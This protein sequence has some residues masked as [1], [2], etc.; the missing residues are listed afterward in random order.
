M[1]RTSD[2]HHNYVINE[3]GYENK[4]EFGP[5]GFIFLDDI[6]GS[7]NDI[8]RI[9]RTSY[10]AGT[11]TLNDD[12]A[13]IRRLMKDY[14]CYHP[15]ME[16]LTLDGW[17]KWGDCGPREWYMI[18]DPVKKTLRPE[19]LPLETFDYSGEMIT[20]KNN[21]MSFCVTP[22]HRMYFKKKGSKDF[23]IYRADEMPKWG[24]FDPAMNYAYNQ[25]CEPEVWYQFL[26][27]FLGDGH[28]A[29]TN[30]ISFHLVKGRKKEYLRALLA[31]MLVPF[32]EK[33]SDKIDGSL[34]WIDVNE[35]PR[36]LSAY[37]NQDARSDTKQLTWSLEQMSLRDISGLYDGLIN[38]DGSIKADR[39]QIQFSSNSPKLL[40][41][42]QLLSV[43]LGNDC[44][45]VAGAIGTVTAY[46]KGSRTT[47][48]ARKEYF[49]SEQ[50]TGKVHCVT[51]STGLLVVR[52]NDSTFGFICGNTSPF[53]MARARFFLRAPIDVVRQL[54]RHRMLVHG[55]INEYCVAP[56]TQVLKT[57]L[58][59]VPAETLELGDQLVGFSETN[60]G[61]GLVRGN[62][63]E[64]STVTANNIIQAPCYRVTTDNGSSIVVSE[65]HQWVSKKGPKYTYAWVKTT[66]L[67]VGNE[68]AFTSKPWRTESSFDAGWLSGMFD[69]EGWLS[70]SDPATAGNGST[71][72]NIH[73]GIAQ[74]ESSTLE[75]IRAALGSRGINYTEYIQNP[76]RIT[77][78]D[79]TCWSLCVQSRWSAYKLLGSIHPQRLLEKNNW[80][81]GH[82]I[83]VT[84]TKITNIEY[85]G[86]QDVVALGTSTKTYIAEGFL[87]HNSTRYS[88][89]VDEMATVEPTAWRAQSTTNKQG[90]AG[91]VTEWSE[92]QKSSTGPHEEYVNNTSIGKYL[93]KRQHELQTHAEDVYLERLDFGVAREQ[94]RMDLP[95]SN[96]TELYLS[97]DAHNL[98]AFLSLRLDPHAQQEI[99]ELA[100]CMEKIFKDWLPVTHQAFLDYRVNAMSLSAQELKA[101]QYLIFE[102]RCIDFI[103]DAPEDR[104]ELLKNFGLV[105]L[106]ERMAFVSKLKQILGVT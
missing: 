20:Y 78:S 56:G 106:N 12:T 49:G 84:A 95:L 27:F 64:S 93:S 94:A 87:S 11:K 100:A 36:T 8:A 65:G 16:V 85:L 33:P 88:V 77:V 15:D 101:L 66:D 10:G 59:W 92:D 30:R 34:F 47:L 62:S 21:R 24:H 52:G 40:E 98:M 45:H 19:Q 72:K 82:S 32:V 6:M 81:E 5:G 14:H 43:V 28:W 37:T 105:S 60:K 25:P 96:Y 104:A 91:F 4:K 79:K 44:H 31:A 53:E 97:V 41:L 68:V 50:Y 73:L 63:L 80:L 48:E 70:V 99:R 26:G 3:H 1:T 89:A 18:P 86:I 57:D 9:A 35:L 42:F 38:S 90:S 54:V 22:N 51:S 39:P 7:D 76:N 23:S 67:E 17:K 102:Q 69:G 46:K 61:T 83:A 71:T 13:L 2:E 75:R 74:S 29:S 55:S 103:D 58:T